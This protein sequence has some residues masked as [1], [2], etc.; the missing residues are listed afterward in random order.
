[1]T[2]NHQVLEEIASHLHANFG[3]NVYDAVELHKGWLNVK[4]QL[5]TER[6]L[7]FVKYYHPN[8]YRLHL[9]EKRKKIEQ[10]LQL[11]TQ[12]FKAELPCPQVLGREGRFIQETAAGQQYALME[13]LDGCTAEAGDISEFHMY[14]LGRTTGRMHW[15][16]RDVRPGKAA[17]KPDQAA[18]LTGLQANLEQAQ[19]AGNGPLAELLE[20]AIGNVRA[21]DCERLAESPTGWLHWDLW[22]DNLLLNEKGV[23]G[24]VDFDRMDVAYPEIDAARAVLSGAWTNKRVRIEAVRAFLEGYRQHAA[25]PKG[26]LLRAL[27]MLYLIESVW[28]LRA[29]ILEDAGVPARFYQELVWLT[30][31]WDRLADLLEGL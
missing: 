30:E 1:M 28:W 24:I 3:L 10:T 19:Q 17:W 27:R 11:Q 22:V 21:L 20:R 16:L 8:R 29:E 15:L 2:A 9:P 25:A 31:E 23:A 13:W 12:L 18:S 4:W 7:F 14:E 6:G 26:M 5:K